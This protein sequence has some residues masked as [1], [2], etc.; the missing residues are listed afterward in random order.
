MRLNLGVQEV[1]SPINTQKGS[2]YLFSFFI[3]FYYEGKVGINNVFGGTGET[4]GG[5]RRSPRQRMVYVW[6]RVLLLIVLFQEASLYLIFAPLTIGLLIS[7]Y[8]LHSLSNVINPHPLHL[9]FILPHVLAFSLSTHPTPLISFFRL[10]CIYFMHHTFLFINLVPMCIV[11]HCTHIFTY[12][13]PFC[14]SNF[15]FFFLN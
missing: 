7:I 14:I 5:A 2:Y 15:T 10:G 13:L 12:A 3:I 8:L 9:I 11:S 1:S 6:V 4:I